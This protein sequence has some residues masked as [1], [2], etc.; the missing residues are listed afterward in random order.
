MPE[1]AFGPPCSIASTLTKL[2]CRRKA[3]VFSTSVTNRLQKQIALDGSNFHCS[4]PPRLIHHLN[5]LRLKCA[6]QSARELQICHGHQRIPQITTPQINTK[7]RVPIELCVEHTR[8]FPEIAP[9]IARAPHS[10]R[11]RIRNARKS[12][13]NDRRAE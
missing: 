3:R 2:Q 6:I 9:H 1:S 11:M 8:R 12:R 10:L 5:Y 13:Q 7:T 4:S